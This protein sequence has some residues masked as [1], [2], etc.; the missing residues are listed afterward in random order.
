MPKYEVYAKLT[1]KVYLGE[2]EGKNRIDA[3]K[4]AIEECEPK[5]QANLDVEGVEDVKLTALDSVEVED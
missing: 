2:Y 4:K 3:A 5:Y 1:G